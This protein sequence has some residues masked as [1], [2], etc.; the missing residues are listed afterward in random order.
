MSKVKAGTLPS[1]RAGARQ[2]QVAA[3]AR[4]VIVRKGLADTTLRDIARQGGF[5]TGVLAHHFP[6]KRAVIFGALTSAWE[7]WIEQAR[8]LFAAALNPRELVVAIVNQVVPDSAAR[9]EEWRLWAEMWAYAGRDEEFAHELVRVD[10]TVWESALRGVL[11]QL[12]AGQLLR[13][14]L[15]LETET[16]IMNRLID[17]L[18]L[19][20]WLSGQ[21]EEA[22]RLFVL[23]LASLGL[24]ADLVDELLS[25]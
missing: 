13:A 14:D 8:Q 11:R 15:D 23:H 7:D 12:Q 18:G 3:A 24:P 21:W 6:D 1:A 22:R 4:R 17:G 19:K 10:T 20:A 9:R 2:G 16:T 25:R 5:T